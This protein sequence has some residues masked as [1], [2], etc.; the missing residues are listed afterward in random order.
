[1]PIMML[2][3]CP[4]LIIGTIIS[5]PFSIL[6][7]I[8][9]DIKEHTLSRDLKSRGRY[10]PWSQVE[11]EISQGSG[12][13][14]VEHF[15]P[16]GPIREWW[17]EEDVIGTAPVTLPSSFPA[18]DVEGLRF[19][20]QACIERYTDMKTGGAKLTRRELPHASSRFPRANIVTLV[21][22]SEEP[23]L[24]ACD[25]EAVFSAESDEEH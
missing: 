13:L 3:V 20:A 25:A 8:V 7:F 10:I 22:W 11:H 21:R 9:Q 4:L 15:S 17:T 19:Y 1:M 16:K 24:V 5:I 12:T 18:E 2:L 6:Y 23:V 14:I